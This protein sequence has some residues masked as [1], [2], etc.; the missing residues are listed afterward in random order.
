MIDYLHGVACPLI[1]DR[2]ETGDFFSGDF[3]VLNKEQDASHDS[4]HEYNQDLPYV[5][6]K[7]VPLALKRTLR[8][9]GKSQWRTMKTNQMK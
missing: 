9:K 7:G 3:V 2:M 1:Y 5:S 8:K 4:V 6:P